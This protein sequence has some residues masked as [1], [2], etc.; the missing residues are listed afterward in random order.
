MYI[1]GMKRPTGKV[2][3]APKIPSKATEAAL[4]IYPFSRNLVFPGTPPVPRQTAPT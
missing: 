3:V 2:C 1:L 4:E